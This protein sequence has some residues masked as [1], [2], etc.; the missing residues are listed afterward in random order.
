M[1]SRKQVNDEQLPSNES[2]AGEE[3]PGAALDVGSEP[4]EDEASG[5]IESPM[6]GGTDAEKKS[7]NFPDGG[8][9]GGAEAF[10]T[11]KDLRGSS[12]PLGED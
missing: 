8:G 10:R 9:S 1:P 12:G 3:D 2:M 11:R 7:H 4:A 5:L 6:R